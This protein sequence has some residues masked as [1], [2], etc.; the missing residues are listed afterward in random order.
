M[1][2]VLDVPAYGRIGPR[3][4]HIP[5][6]A[7]VQIHQ[8]GHIIHHMMIEVQGLQ[9]FARHLGA[10]GVM[11]VE[12]HLA[13]GLEPAGLRFADVMH[14]RGQTQ[15]QIRSGHGA[16]RAGFQCHGAVDDDHRVL[17]HVLMPVMLID[18]QLQGG[19]LREHDVGQTGLDQR[20]DTRTRPVGQQHLD[21]L[22]THT[23]GR[24]DADAVDHIGNRLGGLRLDTEPQL[25][26]EPHRTH[27]AQR[28]VVEGLPRIDRGA[29]HALGQIVRAPERVDELQVGH[30]QR[31]RVDGEIT[32]GQIPL[33]RVAVAD[34]RLT[35]VGIV[36]IR[37]VR[38]HLDLDLG[39]VGAAAHG[40]QRAEFPPHIPEAVAP[41]TAQDRLELLRARG[42]AEIEVMG[43]TVQQ[44]IPHRTTDQR[45]L[46]PL[47]GEQTAQLDGFRPHF[48]THA[49]PFGR[50]I[51][52]PTSIPSPF[53][54]G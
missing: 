18:L 31:H 22:I 37:A 17:E 52:A 4:V 23:L 42:R 25:R 16:I 43:T 27:H 13:A 39:A 11:V 12:A 46:I 14:Q 38:R 32:P 1:P 15:R 48:E 28:V 35:G 9:T 54:G 41:P 29:Q 5:V 7:Q 36:D 19:N 24:Y 21:Q 30:A 26:H 3:L 10:H 51:I 47:I 44:H 2:G 8:L 20:L 53:H 40:P 6:E 49:H 50:R 34:L 45:Q 33:Q